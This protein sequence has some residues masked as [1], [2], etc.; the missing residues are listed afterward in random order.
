MS[1]R[2]KVK[3]ALLEK[4]FG[5]YPQ[6]ALRT[7]SKK[8]LQRLHHKCIEDK[9]CLLSDNHFQYRRAI[10]RDLKHL[11]FEHYRVSSKIHRNFKNKLFAVNNFDVQ[12]RHNSA[13]YKRE[14]IAFS[15]H[16]I[17]MME[18]FVLFAS[19]KN[20]LR[21]MF[22]KKH[23]AKSYSN[24]KSPAM[25]LGITKKIL[26][27]YEFFSERITSHQ[28]RLHE[29]WKNLFCCKDLYSRRPIV[30]YQGI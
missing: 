21:P 4:R 20:Y 12:I 22:F 6:K 16:S 1:E 8:I 17:E 29:D 3:K 14:T 10:Q 28:V 19:H 27:F 9:L 7:S 15:K 5:K 18:K 13:A 11:P 2:Q 30:A 24:K 23:K 26:N 25:I